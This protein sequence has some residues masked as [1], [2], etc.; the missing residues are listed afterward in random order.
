MSMFWVSSN[1]QKYP[2]QRNPAV[3]NS[4]APDHDPAF[5]ETACFKVFVM[6]S[7]FW[8]IEG[9][10]AISICV[11]TTSDVFCSFIYQ[12]WCGLGAWGWCGLCCWSGG[13]RC[14][15]L[16]IHRRVVSFCGHKW[17]TFICGQGSPPLLPSFAPTLMQRFATDWFGVLGSTWSVNKSMVT[18]SDQ[19]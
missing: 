14:A 2:S 4:Q 11:A 5:F 19:E 10:L 12:N 15:V 16:A 3:S 13:S 8:F 18:R 1:Y 6:V 17:F 7:M 9:K